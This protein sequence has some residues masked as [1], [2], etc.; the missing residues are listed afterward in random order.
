LL[1]QSAKRCGY[2]GQMLGQLS[3][4]V[5][6]MQL[7]D[8]MLERADEHRCA[9]GVG[10]D[11]TTGFLGTPVGTPFRFVGS[12]HGLKGTTVDAPSVL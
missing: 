2:S 10:V 11:Q 8:L 7:A 5:G 1:T 9:D 4:L 6:G 3:L 12:T